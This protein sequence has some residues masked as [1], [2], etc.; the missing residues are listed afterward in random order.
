[1]PRSE[2]AA[3]D[4]ASM[5]QPRD[6]PG[7]QNRT[8]TALPTGLHTTPQD[9][10][11]IRSPGHSACGPAFHLIRKMRSC[12]AGRVRQGLQLIS[13]CENSSGSCSASRR[14]T[15]P[16]PSTA[17][18]PAVRP[19]NGSWA[20]AARIGLRHPERRFLFCLARMPPAGET[21]GIRAN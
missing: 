18:L 5:L 4:M 2:S 8:G 1:M 3:H 14:M 17:C 11:W 10:P 15:C 6:F 7:E 20:H 21:T 9:N 16:S 13:G 19:A 12:S